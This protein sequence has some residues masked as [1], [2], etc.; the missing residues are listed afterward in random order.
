M[1]GNE[2]ESYIRHPKE[3]RKEE[4][5]MIGIIVTIIGVVVIITKDILKNKKEISKLEPYECGF[6][7]SRRNKTEDRG[8]LLCNSDIIYSI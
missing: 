6:S 3:Q 1:E 5:E 8:E 4:E 2:F 7:P